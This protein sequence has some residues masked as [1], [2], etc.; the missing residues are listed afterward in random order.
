MALDTNDLLK[1]MVAA[2]S[3]S[4][5]SKWP[6]IRDLATTQ[7]KQLAQNLADIEVMKLK[8]SI[9]EEQAQL[10]IDMQKNTLKIILLTE[11]GLGLLAVEAAINAV[12][13]VISAPVNK[14]LGWSLL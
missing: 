9:T 2:A 6:E 1:Q 14:A 4:L 10:L 3:A 8:G 5:S 7:L 11:E 12:V 13:D